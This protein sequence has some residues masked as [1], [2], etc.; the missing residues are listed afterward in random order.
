MQ[1]VGFIVYPDFQIIGLAAATVFEFAN[2]ANEAS[3]Y[4]VRT[5]SEGGG[6]IAGSGAI[7]VDSEPF[8]RMRFDTLIVCGG[9]DL[10]K[11]SP[12]LVAYLQER[13][14]ST[15]RI[16]SICTGAFV[17]AGA[18]LLNGRRATTH[19]LFAREI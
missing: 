7:A 6:K 5:L 12:G 3:V 10:P 1:R 17:L 14:R 18:G 19:W 15:R 2:L 16:A 13:S 11:A 8:G 9:T 4:D